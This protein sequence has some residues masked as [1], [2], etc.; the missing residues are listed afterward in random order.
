ML[1]M[2]ITCMYNIYVQVDQGRQTQY[3]RAINVSRQYF[4]SA[5][6]HKVFFEVLLLQTNASDPTK[7]HIFVIAVTSWTIQLL[8]THSL[9]FHSKIVFFVDKIVLRQVLL[10]LGISLVKME[11]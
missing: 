11:R 1:A 9:F 3:A 4:R 5:S 2:Y 10:F 7:V 6:D 8:M